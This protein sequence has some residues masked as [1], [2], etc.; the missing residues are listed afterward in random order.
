MPFNNAKLNY[1]QL[2]G[3]ELIFTRRRNRCSVAKLITQCI[4][5]DMI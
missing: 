2:Y 5:C 3:K 1:V 4:K